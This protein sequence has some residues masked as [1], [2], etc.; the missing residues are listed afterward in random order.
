MLARSQRSGMIEQRASARKERSKLELQN[1]SH[2]VQEKI[3]ESY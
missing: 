1:S 2:L 3:L